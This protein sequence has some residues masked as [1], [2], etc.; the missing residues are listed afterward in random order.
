MTR[1]REKQAAPAMPAVY[2]SLYR[3]LVD[4]GRELGYAMAIHGTLANDMDVLAAPWTDEAAPAED[5]VAAV[6]D[7]TGAMD[8]NRANPGK[9]PG[10]K[11]HGRLA[12]T[13]LLDG[14]AYID[15]SVMPR[16]AT[17]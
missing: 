3:V 11:P 13:L 14:G 9:N 12:W 2:C 7:R 17:P 6:I 4:V 10:V 8:L 5:L 16:R 1:P 15:L